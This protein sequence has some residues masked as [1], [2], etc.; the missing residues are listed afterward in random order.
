MSRVPRLTVEL[1]PPL[2]WQQNVRAVVATDT[3]D[4]LRWRFG[5]TLSLP[6]QFSSAD[7]AAAPLDTKLV[8]AYC[9]T[10]QERLDLHEEW[11]Y[12][13]E[14]QVQRLSGLRPICSKCHLVKHMGYA[15]AVGRSDE[16][17]AHLSAMN[18]WTR[19]QAKEHRDNA[20]TIWG[21]R[22]GIAYTLDVSF[23][24]HYI[25]PTKIHMNWLESPRTWVG[26]R[27]DAI[28]WASRLLES[29]AII[30][31]TETTGL[32]E[33]P[34][35]EVIELA[36]INMKGKTVYHGLLK[37]LHKIPRSVIRIHG[38]TNKEV[39]SSPTFAQRADSVTAALHGKVIVA[40]NARF[41]R[42]VIARTFK[43][44]NLEG[45]SAR[46]ECAM[47][48]FRTFSGS[49]QYLRL[50]GSSHRALADCKATL[51][52]IKKMAKADL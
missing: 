48:A 24:E 16:A 10:E 22:S 19:R 11:Q 42:G 18:G 39:K 32:L 49:G 25:S 46:W 44:Y 51:R 9:E 26:S 38:I 21:S 43:L 27:L 15:N 14:S 6:L 13:D 20:F 1:V 47:H 36:I 3:W 52:L 34:H 40:F 5:A 8:C 4:W 7:L 41:D 28:L 35:A 30:L 2:A 37:P 17:L 23:L 33:N 31:D 45:I 29:D 12:D 50:P